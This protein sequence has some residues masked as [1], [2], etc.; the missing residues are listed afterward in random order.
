MSGAKLVAPRAEANATSTAES[1]A[2][3]LEPSA[4]ERTGNGQ[5]GELA[6][7]PT[8]LITPREP[9]NDDN[10]GNAS[11]SRIVTPP[12][13]AADPAWF[14][15]GN[16]VP[17]PSMRPPAESAPTLVE[18]R[19]PNP[20]VVKIVGGVIG[21]CLF[22]VAVA[23]VKI[24]YQR[25]ASAGTRAPQ[26]TTSTAVQPSQPEPAP[27]PLAEAPKAADQPAPSQPSAPPAAPAAVAHTT[28]HAAP[29]HGPSPAR[30][31]PKPAPRRAPAPVTKKVV[32]H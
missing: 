16:T 20:R 5:G 9:A 27:A 22:I 11:T 15:S 1:G 4:P 21:A 18:Q 31:T 28:T 25:A 13:M 12:A 2:I 3:A 19:A 24:L 6:T 23:S 14:R 10:E 26:E 30:V 32:R 17:P 7:A 8:L 29:A